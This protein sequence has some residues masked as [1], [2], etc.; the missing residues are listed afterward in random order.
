MLYGEIY[1]CGLSPLFVRENS[2]SLYITGHYFQKNV[3]IRGDTPYDP[4][5][6]YKIAH[7]NLVK[8]LIYLLIRYHCENHDLTKE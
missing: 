2:M 7:V 8:G 6:Y 3:I 4:L 5:L 1:F